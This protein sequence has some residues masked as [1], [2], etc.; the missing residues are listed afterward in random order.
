MTDGAH[1][2]GL[3]WLVAPVAAG[4]FALVT[5]WTLQHE[6]VQAVPHPSGGSQTSHLG[7]VQHDTRMAARRLARVQ[8]SVLQL[9]SSLQRRSA[10]ADRLDRV[11]HATGR[12]PAGLQGS[13]GSLIPA[14]GPLPPVQIPT[15]VHTT[16]GAS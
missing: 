12:S 6:P 4:T 9:E 8:A 11:L 10:S 2:G 7:A 13:S 3:V 1:G 16:T 15:T 5:Q 14:A